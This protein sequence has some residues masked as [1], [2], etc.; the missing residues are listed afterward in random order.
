MMPQP[1]ISENRRDGLRGTSVV[2]PCDSAPDAEAG[3]GATSK[4]W[5]TMLEEFRAERDELRRRLQLI[6]RVRQD[7][8]V[9]LAELEAAH[10]SIRMARDSLLAQV[11]GLVRTRD[12]AA[13]HIA[14]LT[15]GL[16][17]ARARLS[18]RQ[19]E[20]DALNRTCEDLRTRLQIHE[21]AAS[22][23]NP[24][25]AD[26]EIASGDSQRLSKAELA[27]GLAAA[28]NRIAVL[29]SHIGRVR[30]QQR[31]GNSQITQQLIASEKER[32]AA[33]AAV[34]SL[35]TELG[36]VTAERDA[37][38]ITIARLDASVARLTIEVTDFV[39]H[40][41]S[42]E[43]ISAQRS[44]I[45][46]LT[47]QLDAAREELRL[48]WALQPVTQQPEAPE[49]PAVRAALVEPSSVALDAEATRQAV[50]SMTAIIAAADQ[51]PEPCSHL[52][53]LGEQLPVL[54]QRALCAGW[55][56]IRR[57]ADTC[58]EITRWLVK[59]PI[60][61]GAMAPLLMEAFSLMEKIAGSTDPRAHEDTEG[62]EVFALD[63]D[64]DN[65]ECIA[66][67]LDKIGLRTC[68]A[69][70]PDGALRE[71]HGR[72]SRLI[73]LDVK[74]GCE[75][76]GFDVHTSIRGMKQHERTPVLF[77]TG[78]SSAA[79]QITEMATAYDSYLAKP[80]YLN[81]LSL[82]ALTM[83]LQARLAA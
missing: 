1:T 39:K 49:I 17:E 21:E 63:D 55:L 76:T 83:I 65:C 74:L 26:F 24:D 3:S 23:V 82:K 77:V 44:E 67:A 32:G 12:D 15:E 34:A 33:V 70:K 35:Q 73:L 57:L 36:N 64:V 80:Y 22:R 31:E 56:S 47:G 54:G 19:H 25:G 58:G 53:A 78:Q 59:K 29:D 30:E 38:R 51:S 48:A 52:A 69:T 62:L 42:A 41:D 61:L 81:E 20:L 9:Q 79:R 45:A 4:T 5:I 60:K 68:Y 8:A 10:Q 6:P 43:L 75:Q 13:G 16:D 28:E 37:M 50:A 11:H 14:E 2:S 46:D 72:E 18:L 66:V 71:L 7:A 27:A 40:D